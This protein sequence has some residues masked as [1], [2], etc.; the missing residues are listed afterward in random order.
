MTTYCQLEGDSPSKSRGYILFPT[1]NRTQRRHKTWHQ[2]GASE[3]AAWQGAC[4]REARSPSTTTGGS[5]ASPPHGVCIGREI[6]CT[7]ELRKQKQIRVQNERITGD[8]NIF[9][10]LEMQYQHFSLFRQALNSGLFRLLRIVCTAYRGIQRQ[11]TVRR[12]GV[13][14]NVENVPSFLWTKDCRF[15]NAAK[16]MTEM[17]AVYRLCHCFWKCHTAMTEATLNWGPNKEH[18]AASLPH[19]HKRSVTAATSFHTFVTL[20]FTDR[21]AQSRHPVYFIHQRATAQLPRGSR[22]VWAERWS[23]TLLFPLHESSQR[24]LSLEHW[25]SSLL[26]AAATEHSL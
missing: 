21:T 17:L 13:L 2:A 22:Q 23:L 16:E 15:S 20:T 14:L 4:P 19:S 5:T 3:A 10:S 6:D 25:L 9:L 11:E 24:C 7:A 8:A 18:T 12:F 1:C 26:E